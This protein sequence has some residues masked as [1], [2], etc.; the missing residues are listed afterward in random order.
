MQEPAPSVSVTSDWKSSVAEK[1][2]VI[3][4]DK[5]FEIRV[6]GNQVPHAHYSLIISVPL[7]DFR[8]VF[9]NNHIF[10]LY[11]QAAIL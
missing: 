9:I 1:P 7:P 6:A 3:L 5:Q 8:N 11:G 2:E 10:L 4:I